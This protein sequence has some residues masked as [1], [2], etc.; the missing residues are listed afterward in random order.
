[1]KRE[2]DRV[3]GMFSLVHVMLREIERENEREKMR[4]RERERCL[5]APRCIRREQP[6]PKVGW[7][8]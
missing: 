4:E 6:A 3:Q 2:R 8:E 5:W 7:R 1:M